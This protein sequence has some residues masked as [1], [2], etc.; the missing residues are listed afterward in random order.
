M[1][2]TKY[3]TCNKDSKHLFQS[4]RFEIVKDS[5]IKYISSNREYE[6]KKLYLFFSHD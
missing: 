6:L 3:L 1:T 5:G 2:Q 4:E